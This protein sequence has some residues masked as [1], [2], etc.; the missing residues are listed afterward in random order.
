MPL[1]TST[2]TP[3]ERLGLAIG[4]ATD[5]VGGTGCTVIRG[6]DGPFRCSASIMGR[7][8]ATRELETCAPEHL[9]DR[10]DAILLT[11]GSAYGL[12]AAGGVMKWMEERK[13]G[14]PVGFGVVPIVPTASLFDLEPVGSWSSRPTAHMAFA[15]CEAAD[16]VHIAEGSVG[17]GAG[18]TVGKGAGSVYAMKGGIGLGGCVAGDVYNGVFSAAVVAV[19]AF[20]DIRGRDGKI[21]AGARDEQGGFLDTEALLRSGAAFSRFAEPDR[22]NTTLAVVAVSVSLPKVQLQQVAE[23]AKAAMH[24]RITPCA[25]TYD[26]DVIFAICPLPDGVQGAAAKMPATP[27]LP[28]LEALA[29]CALEKAIERAVRT[30]RG[31][32]GIPGLADAPAP[33]RA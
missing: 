18:A 24:R 30:A 29:V 15:A 13:R 1:S 4:H 31:R 20:G 2:S 6:V 5:Q 22:R 3:W 9:V 21:L 17:A 23:A 16:S 10:T 27:P 19:N 26:G 28:V 14:F 8:T 12:E 25:T 7:A 33:P 11:G 32:D